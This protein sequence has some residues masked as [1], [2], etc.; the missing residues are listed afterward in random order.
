VAEQLLSNGKLDEVGNVLPQEAQAPQS[1]HLALEQLEL[2]PT[3][4]NQMGLYI[5]RT[6]QLTSCWVES[7]LIQPNLQS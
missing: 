1:G 2:Q 3:G 5:Q 7:Q 4:I 6:Q